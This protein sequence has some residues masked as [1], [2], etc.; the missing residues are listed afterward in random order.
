[1][2]SQIN[3]YLKNGNSIPLEKASGKMQN[4]GASIETSG[5]KGVS[6]GILI[7]TFLSIPF[8]IIDSGQSFISKS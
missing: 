7:S 5:Q 4:I 6:E 1:M 3:L 8:Q 2:M